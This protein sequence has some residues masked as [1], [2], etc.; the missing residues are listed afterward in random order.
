LAWVSSFPAKTVDLAV[1]VA[2]SYTVEVTD[3]AKS[4]DYIRKS[5]S[6]KAT[7]SYKGVDYVRRGHLKRLTDAAKGADA[8]KKLPLKK[9]TDSGKATDYLRKIPL[10]KLTDSA[11]S[12]VDSVSRRATYIRE[13]SDT[14]IVVDLLSKTA[15]LHRGLYDVGKGADYVKKTPIK[16]LTDSS[17]AS[18]YIKKKP[19]KKIHDTSKGA[20]YIKR[21]PLR[22]FSDAAK[23][24]DYVKRL[25]LKRLVDSSK[26]VDQI[27]KTTYYV[28]TV[29]DGGKAADYAYSSTSLCISVYDW[30]VGEQYVTAV[31]GKGVSLVDG[32]ASSDYIC[33]DVARVKADYVTIAEYVRRDVFKALFDTSMLLDWFSKSVEKVFEYETSILG[34]IEG[35]K[36]IY[37]A[38]ADICEVVDAAS[39]AAFFLRGFLESVVVRDSSYRFVVLQLKDWVVGEHIP[40]KKIVLVKRE[41]SLVSEAVRKNVGKQAIEA[42]RVMEAFFKD[43]GKTIADL[44]PIKEVVSKSSLKIYEEVAKTAEVAAKVGFKLAGYDVRRVYFLPK[45]FQ[46]WWDIIESQDHN[47]KIEVCKALIEAFKRV[48]DKLEA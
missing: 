26:P 22:C 46:T 5:P 12:G 11:K 15:S 47:T 29:I 13:I 37:V 48:K 38:L 31:G 18:D 14:S 25:P 43:I 33:K 40:I 41:E 4:V 19:L 45:E 16:R 3:A 34:Y 39:R 36:Q 27:T 1:I 9:L 30:L 32:V 8:V 44:I 28:R 7:D 42:S 2:L 17:K 10:K 35:E 24:A 20:D 6:K 21:I 23:G